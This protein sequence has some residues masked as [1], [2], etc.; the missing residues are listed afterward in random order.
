[1]M[2][3]SGQASGQVPDHFWALVFCTWKM[4][5]MTLAALEGWRSVYKVP[6]YAFYFKNL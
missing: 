5:V 1:M 2:P 4:E 3:I 6:G